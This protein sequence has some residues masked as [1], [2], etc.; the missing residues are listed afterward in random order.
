MAHSAHSGAGSGSQY[1][2]SLAGRHRSGRTPGPCTRLLS[3]PGVRAFAGA[4]A[5]GIRRGRGIVRA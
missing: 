3:A 4:I 1:E 5:R 2:A